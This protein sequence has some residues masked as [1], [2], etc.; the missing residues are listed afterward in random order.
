MLFEEEPKFK[1]ELSEKNV[2]ETAN[3]QKKEF[4]KSEK[5]IAWDNKLKEIEEIKDPLGE[6]IDDGIK[7]TVAAFNLNGL[8][9]SG[10]C[11]GHLDHGT[12]AP[13]VEV[14]SPNQPEERFIGE[15]EVFK[16]VAENMGVPLEEVRRGLQK[17]AWAEALEKS[18]EADETLE[19]RKWREENKKLIKKASE[20]LE[21]FYQD[22][23]VRPNIRLEISEVG[24]GGVFRVHNGGD[25]YKLDL[26]RL[27]EK[28][29]EKLKQRLPKYQKEMEGFGKFLKEKYFQE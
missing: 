26:E 11:E 24:P 7:E 12:A 8:S 28:Q 13:W 9:T 21:D 2:E 10:S 14:S 1:T 3:E 4:A 17:N 16:K 20:L 22:K 18:S 6:K 15:K 29:K 27:T 23:K 25:D 19:Y 5:E